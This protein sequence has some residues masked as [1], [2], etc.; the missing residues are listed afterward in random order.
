MAETTARWSG[1]PALIARWG[2]HYGWVVVAV[3]LPTVLITAGLRAAPGVLLRP[4]EQA[5]GWDRAALATAVGINLIFYGAASPISGRL[6]D[7]FGPRRIALFS[8]T[9]TA[10]GA[11]SALF[12]TQLWQL[13]LTWGVLIGIGTGGSALV[14]AATVANRWF[15]T[16]RGLVTG[17]LGGAQSAGQLVFVPALMALAVTAGW[18]TGVALLA[19]LVALLCLPLMFLFFRDQP[20]DVG[21]RPFGAQPGAAGAAAAAADMRRTSL[22][23]A[24]RTLDFWLLAGSFFICGYT[25]NGLIG[26]H[27]I[28]HAADHGISEVATASVLGLMGMMNILGT[29][30]SGMLCDRFDPRRLL[31]IYYLGRGLALALLPFIADVG[32]LSVFAVLYGLDWLA[33][34]PP[35]VTLTGDRFGRLSVGTIFGW[36]FLS[37]QLGGA[38]ASSLG[39]VLYVQQGNYTVAFLS[40]AASTVLAAG[41]ALSVRRQQPMRLSGAAA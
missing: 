1:V 13:Y 31:A 11:V 39:G 33:T 4:W 16:R 19:A 28:P 23:T 29:V 2:V 17:I 10:I 30:A 9:L 32:L 22:G 21:L 20:A 15:A 8:L 12:V 24:L 6:I 41:L 36:I 26:T 14:L 27:L 3:T 25:T 18:Q 5:F 37:H 38:V 35:T 40:A 34:V 7:R